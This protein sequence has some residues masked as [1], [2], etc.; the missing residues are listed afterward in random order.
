MDLGFSKA[1]AFFL[2]A[3]EIA[4]LLLE[5]MTL[6]P[7]LMRILAG[8]LFWPSHNVAGL[9]LLSTILL[10]IV[11]PALISVQEKLSERL[12]KRYAKSTS[13]EEVSN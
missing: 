5:L 10:P 8:H 2:K 3:I 6:T 1:I 13:N 11:I 4:V 7:I 12:Q 9:I